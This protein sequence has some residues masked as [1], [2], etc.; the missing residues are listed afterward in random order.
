MLLEPLAVSMALMTFIP[1]DN[2]IDEASY[3]VLPSL[4][5]PTNATPFKTCP[6]TLI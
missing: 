2:S 3:L 6:Q 5:P 4:L 1:P